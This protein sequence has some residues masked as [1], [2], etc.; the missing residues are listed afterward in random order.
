[1]VW[2][3]GSEPSIGSDI[4]IQLVRIRQP[5]L[6]PPPQA[7]HLHRPRS[8]LRDRVLLQET[9]KIHGTGTELDSEITIVIPA[10]NRHD[11]LQRALHS[12][13]RQSILPAEVI[14]VDDGSEPP[15]ELDQK[16]CASIGVTVMRHSARRGAASAR[17]T[18]LGRVATPYCML[19]DSD[20]LLLPNAVE[21]SLRAL[22]SGVVGVVCARFFVHNLQHTRLVV[23]AVGGRNTHRA[24]A[25]LVGGPFTCSGLAFLSRQY[26]PIGRSFDIK[27]QSLQDL[28]FLIQF[29]QVSPIHRLSE[30]TILKFSGPGPRVFSHA[31]AI[32]SY[33]YLREKY[34]EL[35][36]PFG[37]LRYG[38]KI[39]QA[40]ALTG[41]SPEALQTLTNDLSFPTVLASVLVR[42]HGALAM[43][44]RA[45][46]LRRSAL[47][48]TVLLRRRNRAHMRELTTLLSPRP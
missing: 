25:N 18:G 11:L 30:P 34:R 41:A 48:I 21:V 15:I 5:T 12:V 22:R 19:L 4:F 3:L 32:G 13:E 29:S 1:M 17:N 16:R 28:D 14:V 42:H 8:P 44:L 45:L 10:H 39:A 46:Q 35:L 37:R 9:R 33:L 20:D 31:S 36:T 6:S 2:I 7:S 26:L 27:L 23:P 38:L 24:L 40:Q 43:I 47:D